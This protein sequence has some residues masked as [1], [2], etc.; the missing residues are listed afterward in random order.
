MKVLVTDPIDDAGLA[1]L[2]SAGLDIVEDVDIDT[3]GV[4]EI[5]EDIDAMLIRG[6]EITR[7]VF[8]N[9]PNL[10]VVSRA[11]IGVDNIDIPAATDHGVIVANAPRGNVY[12]AAEHTI[13]LAFNAAKRIPQGHMQVGDGG[14]DGASF[15]GLELGGMTAGIVGLGRLGQEVAWRFDNLGMDLLAYDPYLGEA[16]ARQ[17][18]IELLDLDELLERVDLLSVQAR[19]TD[20]T[21]D[22]IG[23]EQIDRF[24]GDLVVLSSRGGIIDEQALADAVESGDIEAAGVDV[25]STEPPAEDNPLLAVDDVVVTPHLGAKTYNAQVNVAVT[26]ANSIISGLEGDEVQN[27]LNIPSTDASSDPET[28]AYVD[29]A[30]TASKLALRLF[31]GRV[32]SIEI[33]YAGELA[34]E[35]VDLLTAAVFNPF[36]W[37]DVVVDAPTRIAEQRGI[38]VVE[39]RRRETEDYQN[40][41]SITVSDDEH[42]LTVSGTLFGD[43]EPRIVEIDGFRV[44]AT[45]HGTMLISYNNDEPGVIGSLGSI[46]GEYDINI[47]GMANAREAIDGEA[48]SVYNLDTPVSDEVVDAMEADDRVTDVEV[49]ELS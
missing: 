45:P 18:G 44:D 27:A 33:E 41:V 6:T 31:D 22:L 3:D 46:L 47:A 21:R 13:G 5:V 17:M 4:L 40:L 2:R 39:S 14:W 36:G 37:Q 12:A 42:E 38:Q 25:F 16:R 20:E 10:K 32:Q 35:E 1:R 28:R 8:E 19:L 30:E 23:P 29:V 24:G 49:V 34:N 9:A 26:A 43:N 48:M 15:E 11:G 7:E